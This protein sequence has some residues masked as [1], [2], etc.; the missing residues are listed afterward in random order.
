M[1]WV[2]CR[3]EPR[4]CGAGRGVLGALRP[5]RH[6]SELERRQD[7]QRRGRQWHGL[8]HSAGNGACLHHVC[9]DGR[10]HPVL[11]AVG[12]RGGERPARDRIISA[13]ICRFRPAQIALD[14]NYDA[15]PADRHAAIGQCDGRRAHVTFIPTVEKTAA[16]FGFEI[17]ADAGTRGRPLL[18]LRSL[19]SGARRR[20]GVLDQYRR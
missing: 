15:D 6:R 13:S 19:Q 20:A 18:S 1:Y 3:V 12:Y 8:R 17:Q 16:A 11:F 5:P 4:A 2:C 10:R 14:L 9:G 7:L